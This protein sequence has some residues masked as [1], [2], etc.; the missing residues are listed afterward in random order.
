MEAHWKIHTL[1]ENEQSIFLVSLA[2]E[3]TIHGYSI[4]YQNH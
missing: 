1:P 4:R 3:G 2:E